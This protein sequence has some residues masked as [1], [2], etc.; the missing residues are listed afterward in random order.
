MPDLTR[1][2][3][4]SD[5]EVSGAS[6]PARSMSVLLRSSPPSMT[7][8]VVVSAVLIAAETMVLYPLKLVAPLDSLMVVY[9]AGVMLVA[10]VWRFWLAVAVSVASVLTFD[11]FHTPPL[12]SVT[13][14]TPQDQTAVSAFVVVGLLTSTLAGVARSRAAVADRAAERAR[15]LAEQQAALRR[16]ATLVARGVAPS[17]VFAAVAEQMARCLHVDTAD[18]LCYQPDGAA[19]V[20]ASYSQPEAPRLQVG[21]RLTLEGDNIAAVVLRTGHTARMDSFENAAGS[22]AARL[23]ELGLRSRV[24]APVVVDDRVWGMAAVG[25]SRPDPLPS[26]TEERISDFADLVATALANA[27]TRSELIASR[28][29][30]VAAADDARRHLERDLHDGAQQR[31]VALGLQ[32]RMA[33]TVASPEQTD[34]KKQLS[35]L[36]S[37]LTGVSAELQ[38]ISRGIHPSILSEGGLGPALKSL[39]R[40]S[41]VP[42]SFDLAIS[43]RLAGP[44]EIAA[45]YVVA[46]ALTNAAKHAHASQVNVRAETN[47]AT[48]RLSI[49]DNGIGGADS[50]KGTGLI[51]LKD[52]VEAVCGQLRVMSPLGSGTSLDIVIPLDNDAG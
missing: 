22:L 8:G 3:H 9:L 32:A 28:A 31:L 20:R 18:L 29:R 16:V 51:G 6:L 49:H 35:D 33:E 40:R 38:E 15:V 10:I 46:E 47:D 23:R 37:G 50:R 21:E 17:E 5:A 52:R 43:R 14:S 27:A 34:L 13:L 36:A 30:I 44:V 7:L 12:Y 42:V 24:G 25:S 11:Y 19:V 39:G 48:L 45:Y 41:A 26:D 4:T 1:S 2:R